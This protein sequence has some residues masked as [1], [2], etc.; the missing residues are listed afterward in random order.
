MNTRTFRDEREQE[1]TEPALNL[2]DLV[3]LL[4]LPPRTLA[5]IRDAL[6]QWEAPA[7]AH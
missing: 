3:D 2:V 1:P 4:E 5:E 6:S 7:H